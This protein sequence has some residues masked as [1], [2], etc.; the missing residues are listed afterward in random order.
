VSFCVKGSTQIHSVCNAAIIYHKSKEN[1]IGKR[2]E[3]QINLLEE[4][5][6]NEQKKL[7]VT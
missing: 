2:S 7:A 6:Y 5:Y 1:I 4:K 3:V